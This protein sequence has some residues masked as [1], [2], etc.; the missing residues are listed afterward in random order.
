M[1]RCIGSVLLSLVLWSVPTL[2]QTSGSGE[3]N[4]VL[5]V[6]SGATTSGVPVTST[7]Q[8]I[9]T[10][11]TTP[12]PHPSGMITLFDGT[13]ALGGGPLTLA[14]GPASS[15]FPFTQVFG[16]ADASLTSGGAQPS[17]V[18]GD[19][20]GDGALDLLLWNV[21]SSAQT[22]VV[23]NF[24]S[25][26]GGKF[27]L[28]PVQSFSFPSGSV[29]FAPALLDVDGDGHLDLLVGNTVASGKG[30]GT[31]ANLVV[32]PALATGFIQS[33]AVDLTLTAS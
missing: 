14:A 1:A 5:S 7:V 13:T 24:V 10:G 27:V 28:L 8:P 30:D 3:V 11:S 31:F 22:M 26:P 25:A 16:Q 20:N 19:F 32:L 9:L 18:F 29:P 4:A 2:A 23:Q 6:A 21:N 17:G 33:Y 15:A 12:V